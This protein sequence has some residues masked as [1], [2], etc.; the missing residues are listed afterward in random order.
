MNAWHAKRAAWLTTPGRPLSYTGLRWIHGGANTIGGDSSNAVVLTGR[1]VPNVLGTLIRD[2]DK[3]RFEPAAGVRA[4]VDSAP[5]V[6]GP[7]R[8]DADSV[9]PS[10]VDVGTAGFRIIKR[11][12]SLGVRTWDAERASVHAFAGV[13]VYPLD[14]RLRVAGRFTPYPTPKKVA[15]MTEAGMF[16]EEQIVGT[17]GTTVGG[18]H[19]DLTAF[20]GTKP[21]DLF[22]IFTDSTSGDE[23]YGF[24][25]L[26]AAL[27]T[28]TRA[29]TLDWNYAYNPDCAFTPYATC[30][31][32]PP[33]NRI[34]AAIRAGERRYGHDDLAAA[35]RSKR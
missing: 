30:P 6:A 13:K 15:V 34:R 16:E 25:F 28:A 22:I 8:T 32:P 20:V 12:D 31:L 17:V 18:Q 2:G 21:T 7:L 24:R 11:L 23:T 33:E 26:H 10:R 9:G 4:T 14:E 19:Y 3:V 5:A 29:V 35:P 27:D 1:N